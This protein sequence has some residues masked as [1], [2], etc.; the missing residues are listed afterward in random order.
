MQLKPKIEKFRK[1]N[2]IQ[3][4]E[5]KGK[6]ARYQ[7]LNQRLITFNIITEDKE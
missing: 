4:N 3:N 2:K 5:G 1:Y 6:E 7:Q